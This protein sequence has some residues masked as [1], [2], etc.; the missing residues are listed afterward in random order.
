M[1]AA[2]AEKPVGA[3]A[4]RKQAQAL[5]IKGYESMGREELAEAVASASSN[6][7]KAGKNKP[8]KATNAKAS[9]P[10]SKKGKA[11]VK[12]KSSDATPKPAKKAA[13][14]ERPTSA[15]SSGGPRIAP[16]KETPAPGVNPF[17][18]GSNLHVLAPL[19]FK[20]GTRRKLAEK[21]ASKIDLHPYSGKDVDLSDYDKRILLAAQTMRDQFGY[22]IVRPAQPRGL[23]GY[24]RV[25]VP[26]SE[27][28]PSVAS[29][30]K[31][32]SS[33]KKKAKTK[34]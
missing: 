17:R 27:D 25:V 6:G 34:S 9:K 18:K 1:S 32:K 28:D 23:D 33:T 4:L 16:P 13:K 19:L 11:K 2:T 15:L 21:L 14:A 20:G 8:K 31:K 24:I 12:A 7:K 10:A 3:K 30:S 29:N 5:G 26:G 22:V